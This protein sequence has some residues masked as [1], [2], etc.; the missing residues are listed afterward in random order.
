MRSPVQSGITL[1]AAFGRK[2][3][4]K[5]KGGLDRIYRIDRIINSL[6]PRRREGAKRG[7]VFRLRR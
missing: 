5:V 3:K 7:M 1:L 2:A 6:E 4:G